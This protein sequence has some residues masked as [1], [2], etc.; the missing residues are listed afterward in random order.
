LNAQ[1]LKSIEFDIILNEKAEFEKFNLLD[2][3]LV[4]SFKNDEFSIGVKT[5]LD[6]NI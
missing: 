2:S 1:N 5:T 3:S 4:M 6:I